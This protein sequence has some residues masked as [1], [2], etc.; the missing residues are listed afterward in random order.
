VLR[1]YTTSNAVRKAVL[2][3]R[4]LSQIPG[5]VE[6]DYS[7]RLND[8][9]NR[10]CIVYSSDEIMTLFVDGL[11][12]AIKALVARFRESHRRTTYLELVQYARAEGDALRA[13]TT[14]ALKS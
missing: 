10:C 13:R 4:Y 7:K 14:S 1:S 9:G 5:E 2:S 8:A 3:L 6:T 11:D 12:P